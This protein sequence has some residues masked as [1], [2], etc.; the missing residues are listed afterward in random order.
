MLPFYL[1]PAYKDYLWGGEKLRTLYGK[2]TDLVP[3]AESWELSAHPDGLSVVASGEYAG[4]SLAA[5]LSQFPDLLGTGCPSGDLPILIKLIDAKQQLSVQVHPFEAYAQ[6]VEHSHGKTEMWYVLQADPGA[7]LLYGFKQKLSKQ[8]F[9][10]RI[11]D[12]SLLNVINAVEVRPGDV[13]FI[14]AGTLHGIGAGIVVAEIQQNSN[15]TYRIFDYN[16][17]DKNGELRP[18][19]VEKAVDV[20]CLEPPT[21]GLRPLGDEVFHAG[22]TETLLGK[23][24]Y[25]TVTRLRITQSAICNASADSY[26]ALLCIDGC[27]DLSAC[28]TTFPMK[29]GQTVFVPAGTGEYLLS[30]CAEILQTTL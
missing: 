21:R 7:Q 8:E 5:V 25:F 22:Y 14:E 17:R 9:R 26:H 19:H 16:R 10:S 11:A 28:G 6:K 20:T 30:G 3:L 15:C 13:L 2:Q 4:Q 12:G 1:S 18:L 24:E 23:C 29:K 27:C